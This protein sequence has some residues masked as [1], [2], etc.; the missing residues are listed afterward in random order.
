ML[1]RKI[2]ACAGGGKGANIGV[3]NRD[4]I[5]V[6]GITFEC[7]FAFKRGV[8]PTGTKAVQ[9]YPVFGGSTGEN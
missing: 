1:Y 6:N 8:G 7:R 9:I 3:G 4:V 5:G 2:E